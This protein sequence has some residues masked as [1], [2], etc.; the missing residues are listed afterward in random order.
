MQ[1]IENAKFKRCSTQAPNIRGILQFSTSTLSINVCGSTLVPN[2]RGVLQ[3]STSA[4]PNEEVVQDKR[5]I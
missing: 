1:H 4:M 5:Q 2:V 3:H